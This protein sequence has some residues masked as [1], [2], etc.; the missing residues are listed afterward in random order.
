MRKFLII[1]A[2]LTVLS[3]SLYAGTTGKMAG[4]VTNTDGEPVGYAN[5]ILK[6]TEIGG[7]TKDNG[8]Y[9]IINIPPGTYDVV[10]TMVG[11]ATT[12]VEGVRINIDE[13]RTQNITLSKKAIQIGGVTVKAKEELVKATSTTT[14]KTL[15]AEAIEDIAVE[16]VE[17]IVAI[18]A[19]ASQVGGE[20]H[21]RGGRGNEVQYSVDGMSVS[22]PVDGSSAL[23]VDSDAIKDMKVMT[24]GFSAEYGNAQSGII[25]IVTKSGS[26]DYTGKIELN[27]NHL[28]DEGTNKDLVRFALGGPVLGPIADNL[29][30]KFTFYF[31]GSAQ[32][33]DSRYKDYYQA[34]PNEELKYLVYGYD[35][36]TP[37]DSRDDILGFDISDRNFNDYTANLKTKYKITP[38]SKLTFA[39]R[40]DMKKYYP[41]SHAWKYALQHYEKYQSESRQYIATLDQTFQDNKNLKVKASYFSKNINRNPR[42]VTRDDFF[43]KNEDVTHPGNP[44]KDGIEFL[45]YDEDGIID[46]GYYDSDK[47]V[48]AISGEAEGRTINEFV[49][50]GT[51][52]NTF[53]DDQTSN[54]GLRSD[55]EW[56]INQIHGLKSGIEMIQHDI[57]KD[58]L[59]NP[60]V[61][62]QFRYDNYLTEN[63]TI[64]DSF[65]DPNDSEIMIYIYDLD[66]R[67]AATKA[68]AGESDGYRAN[69]LQ[70]SY[71]LLDKME[72]EGM[73]VNAG[74]RFDYWYLGESYDI[75]QGDGTFEERE[76][77][78]D[79]RSQIMVSPRLS[80]SHPIS[81]RSKIIFSYGYQSQFPQMQYIYTTATPEDAVLSDA[82]IIVGNPELKPQTTI[83][84]Q[85]G[86]QQQ[87]LEDY[88]L[89]VTAY[90][91]NIYNYVSTKKVTSEE[92]ENVF[93][94]K[95]I[96]EDYGSARGID[97]NV[98]KK[99]SNYTSGS[100]S[101]SLAW[102]EGN[103][104][105]VVVQDEA[106]NLR[107]FPLDWDI[108]H[109]F[110]LNFEF[111]IKD[112][113]EYYIPF[114]DA[115][116]PWDDFVINFLYSISSGKPYTPA[117]E[118][119]G[120]V[121]QLDTNSGRYDY[122]DN[123]DLKISKRFNLGEDQKIKLFTK[124][125]NLF[126]KKNTVFVYPIS[127]K[128]YDD[129]QDLSE[130][131]SDIVFEEVEHIH[132]LSTSNPSHKSAGRTIMFGISFHW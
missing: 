46:E 74:L 105:A 123:A 66:S 88:I 70:A 29:K 104:S 109:K 1:V 58:R 80:F 85:V 71:Y 61:I 69:P 79:N 120:S 30:K 28:V 34:D 44:D 76:F 6:G 33:D 129:G 59:F 122:T 37:Y 42:G 121:T 84:Y 119:E 130:A 14:G 19:G 72:W 106:T 101:Y 112:D 8:T 31:N 108:R 65:P 4:K 55:F 40:G 97:I 7:Q 82:N 111:R 53:I 64:I 93:W 27:S 26:E 90:F 114:T 10:C 5:V 48:F 16:D 41:Y 25:N 132:D 107:E 45:D 124:I 117:I 95:Y 52:Y 2:L 92:D 91:K 73:I 118:E 94:Y 36:Y 9:M 68:A 87:L 78:E 67:F 32:W 50:P 38:K 100:A 89:D 22:D 128:P 13:T 77:D 54:L 12:T 39:V 21:F 62:N 103:N 102:A 113:E 35:E 63:G 110:S 125:K 99:L 49:T 17:G 75:L 57:E 98:E 131:N 23:T 24:G 3:L 116:L 56:Q 86:Y 60:S 15:T 47:W 115:I 81:E 43:A 96:S 126:D 18:Q 83:T 127:G 51:M 20:L 11:Y